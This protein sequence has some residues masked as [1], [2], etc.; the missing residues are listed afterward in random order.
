MISHLTVKIEVTCP[1]CG[2]QTEHAVETDIPPTHPEFYD[3][4][5]DPED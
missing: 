3:V 2:C 1:E 5:G 4:Y